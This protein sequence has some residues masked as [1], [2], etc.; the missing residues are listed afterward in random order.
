MMMIFNYYKGEGNGEN[1][2]TKTGK[3][4]SQKQMSVMP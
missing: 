1:T 2:G 3:Y 4:K